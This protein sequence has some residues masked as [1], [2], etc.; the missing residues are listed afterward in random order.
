MT[1]VS[2]GLSVSRF[3]EI[4]RIPTTTWYR[5]RSAH[6]ADDKP[7]KG[8]WPAPVRAMVEPIAIK[9]ALLWPEWGHRKIWALIHNGGIKVSQATVKRALASRDLLQPVRYQHGTPR[10]RKSS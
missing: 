6:A 5:W 3:C 9:Y 7:G 2:S 8:P 10:T 1:R 4:A